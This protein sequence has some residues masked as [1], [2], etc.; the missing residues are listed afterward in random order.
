VED[1][2]TQPWALALLAVVVVGALAWYL[3]FSAAR[4]D[5]LHH[6]VEATRAALD[7]QLVRRATAAGELAASG[8]LD[9]ATSLLLAGAAAEAVAAGETGDGPD[10]L[11]DVPP[12]LDARDV[13]REAA[14]SDLSRALRAA[15]DDPEQQRALRAEPLGADLLR[16]LDGACHRVLLARRFHND[17][18]T[19]AARVRGKRVVRWARLSGRAPMP[20]TFE[21][22]DDPPAGSTT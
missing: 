18:V 13:R 3:S 21:M 1:A 19:Q 15:L 6:R 5:R 17:A 14:E 9:P 8:L 22:D 7:N 4:L 12:G 20:A 11:L 10:E 16:T 2:V